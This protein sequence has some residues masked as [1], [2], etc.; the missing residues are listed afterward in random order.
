MDVSTNQVLSVLDEVLGLGGRSA[1]FGRDTR[2]LGAIP[3]LDSTAVV[4][5]LARLEEHFGIVID[6]DTDGLT[7]ATGG[8]LADFVGAKLAA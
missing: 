2:L 5:L 4:W 8:N 1:S 6:D 7:F 3:E